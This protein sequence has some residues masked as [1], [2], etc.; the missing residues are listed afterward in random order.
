MGTPPRS[1][2]AERSRRAG[3]R[4]APAAGGAGDAAPHVVVRH[5]SPARRRHRAPPQHP[6]PRHSTCI[7]A[8]SP[9]VA[10]SSA[11]H[12]GRRAKKRRNLRQGRREAFGARAWGV[13]GPGGRGGGSARPLLHLLPTG[14]PRAACV[15][16]ASDG[17][18]PPARGLRPGRPPPPPL[19]AGARHLHPHRIGLDGISRPCRCLGWCGEG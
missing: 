11:R 14:T 3:A 9:P 10:A 13:L 18:R 1:E 17:R 19:R 8:P 12:A 4:S 16:H 5:G 15:A 6:G 2:L 7:A